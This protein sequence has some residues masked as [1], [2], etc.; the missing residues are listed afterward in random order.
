[1]PLVA[2]ETLAPLA[3][4]LGQLDDDPCRA[5]DVAEPVAVSG[6]LHLADQLRAAGL[7][8]GDGGVDVVD[9]ERDVA[10][11]RDVRRRVPVAFGARRGV[12]LISISERERLLFRHDDRI[13][14]Y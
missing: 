14:D 12:K 7:Q 3:D 1:M 4:L 10:E 9:L 13:E 5:A 6:A 2:E 11:A 8:A